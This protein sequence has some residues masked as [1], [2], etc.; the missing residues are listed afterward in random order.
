MFH[1]SQLT[2]FTNTAQ[3]KYL[4]AAVKKM[5][6]RQRY[7]DFRFELAP[8]RKFLSRAAGFRA[9]A[10]VMETKIAT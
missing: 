9:R 8:I 4:I 6:T 10:A 2:P 7:F 3:D 1:R 5:F